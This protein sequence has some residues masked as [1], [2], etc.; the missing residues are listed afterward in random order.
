MHII[1]GKMEMRLTGNKE[2]FG[3]E[4]PV[5][6]IKNDPCKVM[7]RKKIGHAFVMVN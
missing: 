2:V 3:V 6:R 5:D 1:G 4:N 7:R